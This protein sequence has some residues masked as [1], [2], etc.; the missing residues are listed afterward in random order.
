MGGL[1]R[2]AVIWI[3]LFANALLSQHFGQITMGRYAGIHAPL[4]NPALTV[5]TKYNWHINLVGVWANFNN[6]YVNL[7]LPYSAYRL[8]NNSVPQQYLTE[9]NNP[10]FDRDWLAERLNGRDK[11]VAA[12]A[13]IH[14]PSFMIKAR[15]NL[16]IG[17]VTNATSVGRIYGM[18]ENLAHALFQELD[19]GRR[20]FDLFTLR[21]A[22]DRDILSK[23]TM[24]INSWMSAGITAAYDIPVQWKRNV[25]VGATLKKVWG[26]G[27][28][29]YQNDQMDIRLISADSVQ[30]NRTFVQFADY[31]QRGSGTGLDLGIGYTFRKKEWMQ[32]GDYKKQ[33]P[34]YFIQFGVAIL[35]MGSVRYDDVRVTTVSNNGPIGW[36][37]EAARIRYNNQ[38]PGFNL[39]EQV[40]RDIPGLTQQ[41]QSLRIGLP[42][43]LSVN[44]D[45]QFMRNWFIQ[46]QWMQSMRGNHSMAARHQ[47]YLMAGPRYESDWFA[48]TLPMFL[49]Y[50]YRAF[51]MGFSLRA[52]P[53]YL[54][55][56][57]LYSLLNT[58]NLRDADFFIGIAFGNLPGKWLE[59]FFKSKDE[60]NKERRRMDCEKL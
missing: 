25:Q 29:Y 40:I 12:G 4:I 20:A 32:S 5:N 1:K 45:Y 24:S 33:H 2:I 6:N 39:A 38:E 22:G 35:D 14:G 60:K 11:K 50:D 31:N 21:T 55:S 10:Y 47:S 30:L 51:R 56:N 17:L 34:D 46:T 19:T 28:A 54:G 58:R 41:T 52:G 48:A 53:L 59:R 16:S 15:K 57:S 8:A 26:F 13:M 44:A 43:R 7:K 27:G 37:A 36:N 42:T 49:E 23:T 9:N 3:F 18:G